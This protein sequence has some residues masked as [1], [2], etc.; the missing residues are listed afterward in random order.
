MRDCTLLMDDWSSVVLEN[1][2]GASAYKDIKLSKS[3]EIKQDS[4]LATMG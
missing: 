1:T 4:F 3:V 2:A